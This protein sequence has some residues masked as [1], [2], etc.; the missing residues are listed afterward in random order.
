MRPFGV[1]L[2]CILLLFNAFVCISGA[3]LMVFFKEELYPMLQKEFEAISKGYEIPKELF[4]EIYDKVSSVVLIIG[5][6]F[7]I[8]AIG[9]FM[10]KNWARLLAIAMF[11]FQIL[12][13][14]LILPNDPLAMINIAIG[15]A[16]ILYL[17]RGEVR[18]KFSSKK[19]SIEE[20]ILGQKP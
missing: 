8:N 9:L 11:I 7:L 17:F 14:A 19:I 6:I 13:S 20:R 16:V 15:F 3:L 10:L 12:Y 1:L 2:I 5:L 4:E 18:E